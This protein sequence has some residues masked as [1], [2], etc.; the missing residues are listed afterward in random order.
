MIKY[1][2]KCNKEA[3]HYNFIQHTKQKN[4]IDRNLKLIKCCFILLIISCYCI[5]LIY[6]IWWSAKA[7]YSN[8]YCIVG[9][10]EQRDEV[11]WLGTYRIG[12]RMVSQ[13]CYRTID[14]KITSLLTNKLTNWMV[15]ALRNRKNYYMVKRVA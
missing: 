3:S 12:N 5:N 7:S 2:K 8:T 10:E 9:S 4:N 1:K 13:N 6:M 14:S 11:Y 15:F